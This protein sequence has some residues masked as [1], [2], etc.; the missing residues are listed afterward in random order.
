M[1]PPGT[2]PKSPAP[3]LKGLRVL[4]TGSDVDEWIPEPST[5]E[6]A[7][8]LAAL[9]AEVTLRVYPGRKHVINEQ[10][11]AEAQTLL[12]RR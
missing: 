5:R 10:E 4:L 11:I 3:S 12:Q 6:T 8:V 1:G 2:H 9:G 7:Q